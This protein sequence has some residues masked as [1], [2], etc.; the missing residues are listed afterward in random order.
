MSNIFNLKRFGRLAQLQLTLGWRKMAIV[1]AGYVA[2]MLAI[3]FLFNM[4]GVFRTEDFNADSINMAQI[5]LAM[6]FFAIS[7]FALLV[8]FK[9][10]FRRGSAASQMMLPA[11]RLEKF[12]LTTLYGIVAAPVVFF[13]LMAL[14]DM[15]WLWIISALSDGAIYTSN[16]TCLMDGIANI[17]LSSIGDTEYPYIFLS[18]IAL[19]VA[20]LLFCAT[21]YKKNTVLLSIISISAAHAIM[22][23]LTNTIVMSNLQLRYSSEWVV[24][25]DTVVYAAAALLN[26]ISAV[27]VYLSWRRFARLQINK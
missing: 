3:Y 23:I 24:V 4:G 14:T 19:E 17:L 20:A 2:A 8:S 15:L 25:Q 22:I 10:Y 7:I 16:D 26:I 5:F 21:L 18:L 1:C 9:P 13:T 27:L 6:S 12:S 11:T